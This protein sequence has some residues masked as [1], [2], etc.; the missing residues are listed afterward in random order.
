VINNKELSFLKTAW[1]DK[2]NKADLIKKLSERMKIQ[3][4]AAKVIVDNIFDAKIGR[5][6]CRE[7]VCLQV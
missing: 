2:M 4:R 7:R 3:P 1:G 6:S 5:A